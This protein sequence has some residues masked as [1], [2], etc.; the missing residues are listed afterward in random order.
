[1]YNNEGDDAWAKG[2]GRG[3]KHW[4]KRVAKEGPKARKEGDKEVIGNRTGLSKSKSALKVLVDPL[5]FIL[6][7]KKS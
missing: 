4:G 7:W 2:K 3:G 6:V 5:A 1:M